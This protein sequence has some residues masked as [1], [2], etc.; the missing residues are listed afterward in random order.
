MHNYSR[1]LISAVLVLGLGGIGYLWWQKQQGPALVPIAATAPTTTTDAAATVSRAPDPVPS[2]PVN[3]PAEAIAPAQGAPEPLPPLANDDK[4]VS[5]A[6]TELL[7]RAQVLSFLD[8]GDFARR[9]VATVD[10]LARG[11]A[12]SRLWPVAPAPA[13]SLVVEQNGVTTIAGGNADRRLIADR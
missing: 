7:G 1:W 4:A 11:D 3:Y 13:R 10:N 2:A 5:E 12:A 9:V 8:L 6:V